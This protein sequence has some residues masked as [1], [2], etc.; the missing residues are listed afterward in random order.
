MIHRSTGHTLPGPR[1]YSYLEVEDTEPQTPQYGWMELESNPKSSDSNLG[2]PWGLV[3]VVVRG[4]LKLMPHPIVGQ[5]GCV[6]NL[7]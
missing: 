2:S 1:P 4:C 3:V 5:P 7:S 6:P